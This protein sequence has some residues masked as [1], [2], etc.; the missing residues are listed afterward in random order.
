[1]K[2]TPWS[3]IREQ[4][5]V[6]K[7]FL[8]IVGNG[9][10]TGSVLKETIAVSATISKSVEKWHRRIRLRILSCSR[11]SEMHREPRVAGRSLSGRMSRWPCKRNLQQLI[12]WKVAPSIMLVPQ[13]REWML[14]WWKVLLCAS[15]G[16]RT[17]QQKV[18]NEWWQKCTGYV[19]NFTTSG[20]RVS[21]YGAAE[22]FIDF[23]EELKH[24]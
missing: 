15:P 12:L 10:P 22:V 20:L 4:N 11:E 14:I 9:S 21:G 2:G 1:M 23:T 18:Q 16:C 7:E 13:I 6:D 5:S 3:R 24:A 8:E 19:E 17:A